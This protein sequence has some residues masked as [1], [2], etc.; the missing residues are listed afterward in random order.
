MTP[1]GKGIAPMRHLWLLVP[2]IVAACSNGLAERQAELTQWIGKPETAL[3]STMGVPNRTYAAGGMTFLT[4]EDRQVEIV[5]GSPY[6]GPGPFW[7]G[8][9]FP[10]TAMTL[11]CT[12]T[13]T[14]ADG[15]VRGFSLN[16]NA[17][18]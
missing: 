8:G 3:I 10:P 17:C 6:F 5:P 15:V 4:F 12:T 11:V 2:G 16:G 18:G 9:G 1:H 7:Y 14:V 13:F